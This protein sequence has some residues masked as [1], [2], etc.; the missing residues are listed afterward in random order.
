MA[1]GSTLAAPMAAVLARPAAAADNVRVAMLSFA[2]V[3]AEG[4]AK[5]VKENPRTTMVAIW[6]EL[7]DRGKAAAERYGVPFEPK[8]EA[9]LGRDD[10]DAVV[11]NAPTNMHQE[12]YFAACKRKKHIFTEKALT[13]KTSDSDAVVKAVEESGIKFM[14]SLP[15][16]TRPEVLWLRKV[17]DDGLI[18]KLTYIRTR[19]AHSAALDRW[20]GG[21]KLWFA[22]PVAAGGGGLFDLGCHTV[23]ITRWLGGEPASVVARMNS[24]TGAYP[25]V[26]DNAVAVVEFRNKA[27]GTMECG[28]VQRQGPNPMELYGTEGYA[29]IGTAAGP[30]VLQSTKV[31]AETLKDGRHPTE[32]PAALPSPMDQWIGAVLD[33]TAMTI[34]VRDG[35]NLTELLDG[36]Y[37]SAQQ[38]AA[39]AFPLQ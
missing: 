30:P 8:V 22:D 27:L 34:T 36:C 39:I 37:R 14:I 23:D 1:S 35:R 32:L 15:S 18:G 33:G 31:P 38:N 3:H 7:P 12:L 28:W 19:I 5:A 24:F 13:V 2:H 16:R 26:D 6:D 20:F 17:L 11:V 9:V 4:Y 29:A 10:V 21:D 25:E